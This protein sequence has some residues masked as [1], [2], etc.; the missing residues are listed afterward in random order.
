MSWINR[1]GNL[2]RTRKLDLEI[3]EEIRFHLESRL[4]DNIRTGMPAAEARQD[5]ARRF[6]SRMRAAE[7]AHE[8]N[9]LIWLETVLQ[10]IRYALRT[11]RKNVGFTVVAVGSLALGIG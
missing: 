2:F 8:S 11:L 7:S 3:D 1:L 6:G 4:R 10:D 5:A 9:V